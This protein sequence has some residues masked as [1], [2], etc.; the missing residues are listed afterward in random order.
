MQ[1]RH[2]WM[3]RPHEKGTLVIAE[4]S[5]EGQLAWLL[6]TM[7]PKYLE[8]SMDTLLKT[9]KSK[10]KGDGNDEQLLDN[11]TQPVRS[12]QEQEPRQT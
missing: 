10:A 3:F 11:V 2:I 12:E 1:A 7:K 5:W 4:E 9:L 8:E 6:K